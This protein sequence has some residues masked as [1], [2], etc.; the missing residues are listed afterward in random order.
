MPRS[1]TF[2]D[3]LSIE[4]VVRLRSINMFG[5]TNVGR[6]E[7]TNLQVAGMLAHSDQTFILTNWYARTD[8][9]GAGTRVDF[10]RWASRS[11]VTLVVGERPVWSSFVA[12]ILR[13]DRQR[14]KPRS[15]WPEIIPPRY[16]A[17]VRLE[18]FGADLDG[19]PEKSSRVWVHLEG[20]V[21][22]HEH[23]D[24]AQIVA[25]VTQT[26]NVELVT[27]QRICAWLGTM[28]TTDEGDPAGVAQLHAIADG[29]LEGRHKQ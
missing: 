12:E 20:L 15:N 2:W 16:N 7:Y 25:L 18:T 26:P 28:M 5:G 13:G 29:I 14:A 3:S 11:T 21:L 27:E 4:D 9:A 19:E 24:V 8:F 10:H 17:Q 1:K 23:D 6:F 22:D